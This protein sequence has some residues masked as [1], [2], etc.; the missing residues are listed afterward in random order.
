M[1]ISVMV[2]MPYCSTT[3]RIGGWIW[4]TVPNDAGENPSD[5]YIPSI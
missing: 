3:V 1:C 2:V 5:A 4:D